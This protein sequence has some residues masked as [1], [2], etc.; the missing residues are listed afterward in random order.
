MTQGDQLSY[1]KSVQNKLRTAQHRI[2]EYQ[3]FMLEIKRFLDFREDRY[4]DLRDIE[5]LAD[6]LLKVLYEFD[7]DEEEE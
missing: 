3:D 2:E 1:H 4:E 5:L 7:N 6:K